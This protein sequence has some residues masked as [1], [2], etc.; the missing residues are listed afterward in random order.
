[1]IWPPIIIGV[2]CA[3]VGGWIG[4]LLGLRAASQ[5]ATESYHDC[6]AEDAPCDSCLAGGV[7]DGWSERS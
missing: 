3:L 6:I 4:F 5:A 7:C 2:V 1:M